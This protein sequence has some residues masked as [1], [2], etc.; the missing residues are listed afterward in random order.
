MSRLQRV[1]DAE[2]AAKGNAAHV[3]DARRAGQYVAGDVDVAPDDTQ[4][5]VTCVTEHD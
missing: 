2:V 5:P 3:H 1:P 4:R